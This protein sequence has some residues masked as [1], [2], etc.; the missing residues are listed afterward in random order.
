MT[1]YILTLS[2]RDKKGIVAAVSGFLL[3]EGGFIIDST[4]FGDPATDIFFMRT[5]FTKE[6]SSSQEQRIKDKF[7]KLAEKWGMTWEL[8]DASKKPRVM[9]LVSKMGHCLNTLLNKI[10]MGVLP[11]EVPCVISNHPDL[12]EMCGWYS[13]PFHYLPV[14]AET[15]VEQEKA[16]FALYQEY[17]IDLV[18][19]ARYMQI[20]S[21]DL[22]AKVYGRVINI[23]HSFLPSFKGARPY[24]QAYEKGVK[25]IGAT[26]HYVS[27]NLDEGPI[28]EQEAARVDHKC[29]VEDLIQIGHDIESLVLFRAVKAH[30]EQRVFLDQNK[31]V[32]FR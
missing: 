28:I 12:E 8:R 13:V 17:A 14:N 2:C 18:V 25:L 19:L 29:T 10:A 7:T 30:I 1:K 15:K 9:V 4:Q 5:V 11:I 31:T 22:V 21:P 27:E 26:A 3:A 23:H 20:L 32:V 24:H 16:I 6:D